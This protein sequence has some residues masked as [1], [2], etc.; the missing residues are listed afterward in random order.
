MIGGHS[1]STCFFAAITSLTLAIAAPGQE[2]TSEDVLTLNRAIEWT[3]A[4]NRRTKR[5]K[6]DIDKQTEASAEVKTAYYPCYDP[7]LLA[8]EL[9]RRA[10]GNAYGAS[11]GR[12]HHAARNA[13]LDESNRIVS[14]D[15][16]EGSAQRGTLARRRTSLALG[17]QRVV[18]RR[19]EIPACEWLSGTDTLASPNEF[20]IES[21]STDHLTSSE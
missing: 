13:D 6:F 12:G 21:V 10:S 4:N 19:A 8:R 3:R 20:V 5:A 17:G 7:Y 9:E 18:G 16:R 11:A 15:R 2:R 1:I 14:P